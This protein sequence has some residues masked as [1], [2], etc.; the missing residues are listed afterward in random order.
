MSTTTATPGRSCGAPITNRSASFS[1]VFMRWRRRFRSRHTID[2]GRQDLSGAARRRA[3]TRARRAVLEPAFP[4]LPRAGRSAG[5]RFHGSRVRPPAMPGPLSLE[6][7]ND[8]FRAGSAVRTAT[9]GLRSLILLEDDVRGAASAAP[10]LPLQPKAKSRGVGFIEFAVSEE[11]GGRPRRAC[12]ASSAF[13][14]PARIAARTSSAG[15]RAISNSSSIASRTVLR[16]RTTSRT[17]PASAPSRSM[18]TM[19]ARPWRAP[20]R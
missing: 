2:P 5:G 7:F 18:S 13:A 15:R 14:R 4:L 16:I 19:P 8:Q 12:S 6:I 11:Q 9:D 3:E 1:T 20:K 17:V 10:A